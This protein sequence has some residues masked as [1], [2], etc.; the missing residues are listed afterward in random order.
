MIENYRTGLLW[1]LFMKIPDIQNGLKKL[2]F[3]VRGSKIEI[4]LRYKLIS[5]C[6]LISL[7]VKA[8]EYEYN[9]TFF[10][11]SNMSGNY[12]S[13]RTSASG[14]S[15]IRNINHKLPVNDFSYHTPGNS[16]T[17]Q[18]KN[19]PGGKWNAAIFYRE[20]RGMDH[21]KNANYLPFWI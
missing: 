11:N 9:Y 21:F 5:Y 7:V 18:Y 6:L 10:T 12:F 2:A 1:K 20:K 4:M 13:S 15:S 19:A 3:Q 16:L 8:Q 14:N 17:L